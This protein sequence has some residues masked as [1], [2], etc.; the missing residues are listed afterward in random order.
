[1]PLAAA[2]IVL[3][4]RFIEESKD[5]SR[6]GAIDWTGATLAVLGLSGLVFGLLEWPELGPTHPLVISALV[7]GV[8]SLALLIVVE[9]RTK[10]PMLPLTLF[11]SR[12]FA[13]TNLLTL[14]LYAALAEVL[15]L[16]PLLRSDATSRTRLR[17]RLLR[18]FAWQ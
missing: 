18:G 13:F 2:V 1:M 3:S 8:V 4:L 15:F 9:H 16:V 5:P 7:V 17:S 10:N 14:F 12:N 11:S 6:V